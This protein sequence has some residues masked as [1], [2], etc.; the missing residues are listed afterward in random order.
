M[1]AYATVLETYTTYTQRT[2]SVC[3]RI[4]A[5]M[6]DIFHTLAYASTT[7]NSVTGPLPNTAAFSLGIPVFA[8]DTRNRPFKETD[9]ASQFILFRLVY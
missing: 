3:Q 8:V 1:P 4:P 2:P 7:R 6:S 5:Y 9:K